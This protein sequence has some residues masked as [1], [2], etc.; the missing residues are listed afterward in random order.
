MLCKHLRYFLIFLF[1]TEINALPRTG[2]SYYNY[3]EA[4]QKAIFFYKIQRSG[5]LPDNFPV[6]WRADS[7]LTDGSDVGL[8]LTGGWYDC[9]DGVKVGH[10]MAYAA[11]TLAWAVYEYREAF[12][13]SGLLND[14]LDEIKWATD[15]F[16]K[17][18]PSPNEFYYY[19]GNENDHSVW[20]PHEVLSLLTIRPAYKVD[21]STP[22]SDVAGL[23]AAALAAASI[24]F[25]PTNL[26]YA[27]LCLKHA[28]E[29]FNFAETYRGFAPKVAFYGSSSYLDD[30]TWAAIWLY[31]ATQ[32]KEY[33]DKAE[34]FINDPSFSLTGHHTHCWDDVR[35][36][37]VLKLAELTGK[38]KY[39]NAVEFNLDWWMPGG[40]V[41]YTPG[42]IASFDG[43]GNLRY[44]CAAAF[45][46]FKWSDTNL[47]SPDKKQK[48]RNFAESQINYILGDN[49]N[50][51][52][53]IVGF[54]SKYPQHPHHRTAHCSWL[55]MIDVPAEHTHIA[56]GLLVGGPS[57]SDSYSDDVTRYHE[58]EGGIDYN[59]ALVGCLAKMYLL[60]GGEP[61]P[62]FPRPSDFTPP[63]Q[64]RLEYFVRAWIDFES[65]NSTDFI[66]KLNNRSAWPPTVK[67][68]LSCRYFFDLTEL[69]EQGLST[70]NIRVEL[71]SSDGARISG[72]YHWWGNIYFVKIDFSGISI[73]PG[74]WADSEKTVRFKI[75]YPSGKWN[76][77]NDFSYTG[78]TPV[79]DTA[80]DARLFTAATKYIPVYDDDILLWGEVPPRPNDTIPPSVPKN[81]KAVA[82]SPNQIN[83]TWDKN[84]E[85]VDVYCYRIYR[86][87]VS[88]VVISSETFVAEVK[89]RE[90]KDKS[91]KN[92]TTYYYILVAVDFNGNVSQPAKAYATTLKGPSSPKNLVVVSASA[93]KI[94]LDWQDNPET[95]V[96]KYR[97][98][99]STTPG[100]STDSS[101]LVAE[102]IRESSYTDTK[103]L[104][105]TTTYYYVVTAVDDE[106]YESEPSNEVVAYT[107]ILDTTP[108]QAPTGL[109]FISVSLTEIFVDWDDNKE[110]DIS[111]YEIYR[112]TTSGF[113]P[114]E[115]TFIARITT[116]CYS[117][118]NLQLNT[119]YYYRVVAV[120]TSGNRSEPSVEL[121][122]WPMFEFEIWYRNADI[123]NDPQWIKPCIKVISNSGEETSLER[124]KIRYWFT[125]DGVDV[126]PNKII[127]Y[128]CQLENPY[129]GS[130]HQYTKFSFH[131]Y[132]PV[133]NA[134]CYLEISFSSG[135]PSLRGAG[136]YALIEIG[137]ISD[138]TG[139]INFD[140]TN[141]YSCGPPSSYVFIPW[142]R[143]TLYKDD[144]LIWGIEPGAPLVSFYWKPT[145][146]KAG[147]TVQFFDNSAD[148]NGSIVE[149]LW[150]F[151]DGSSTSTEKNPTHVYQT[152]GTYNVKLIVTDNDGQ[153][154][155]K[156][157]SIKIFAESDE[158]P[159]CEILYP[160]N[161]T[162]VSSIITISGTANDDYGISRVELYIDDVLFIS[163]SFIEGSA[164]ES[165]LKLIVN[166]YSE[167]IV[168]IS[169]YPYYT[170]L[171]DPV[172]SPSGT[173]VIKMLVYDTINQV[174]FD[175]KVVLKDEPPKC[176]ILYP[177]KD[178]I[179]SKIVTIS[180]TAVDDFYITKVEF[181]INNDFLISFSSPPYTVLWNTRDVLNGQYVIKMIAYDSLEQFSVDE[182][183]VTVNNKV[184]KKELL[185]LNND[186]INDKLVFYEE[187]IK[188]VE[189]YNI[190]GK[191]VTTIT[192]FPFVFDGK[193]NSG[194]SLPTGVYI[195]KIEKINSK[196]E[197][198]TVTVIK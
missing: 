26:P 89:T 111:H 39:V 172:N 176:K 183:T 99:R 46:A 133:T 102:V 32:E 57:G 86:D 72:L 159:T 74:R 136:Q 64:R 150:D 146:P 129:T 77:G 82:V 91:L 191:L 66:I 8:D 106:G 162:I 80:W 62:N 155:E 90:Y 137:L 186:G 169:T 44:V 18:H 161:N 116:S 100:V 47:C 105:P 96:V 193:D 81:F 196:P 195:Y 36:G 190:K 6:I 7:C 25:K 108:P 15:Y 60:Y 198:G 35:Y 40:G 5:D 144:T 53:Y 158:P 140:E 152:P 184:R 65:D 165:S 31:L 101:Q 93:T 114:N 135:A 145:Y 110:P 69:F 151:G 43:W 84:E 139:N 67:N 27:E 177:I 37:A 109:T 175:Q 160:K 97:V 167:N 61:I 29:L 16:I 185:S 181:Y 71:I 103:N 153:K 22:G 50:N 120:D 2:G 28:K 180:G 52:S 154:S 115:E 87:V 166:K 49:P 131:D 76:H 23:T 4:L 11:S 156:I 42:G 182:T 197:F 113:I 179:V 168:F 141:D 104:V 132:G 192:K 174:G 14:I 55:S 58:T 68:K 143:I 94:E 107:K 125:K 63:E 148:P 170:F 19:V 123:N 147:Q 83:L 173:H 51:M 98:Y 30:L 10:T 118:K 56:Y 59:A 38:A 149:W 70:S 20:V 3:G 126:T 34:T 45:L 73:F 88:N 79:D 9:G 157:L 127:L 78:L 194:R 54:S 178:D 124:L 112:S 117:D 121:C 138:F 85:D 122:A 1:L 75:Q 95:N 163:L 128:T 48:Y 188:K 130:L 21:P 189:I 12:E 187:K 164:N 13:K 92:A 142:Q 119:L 134:D 171:W 33:L 24:I 17:C 41:P